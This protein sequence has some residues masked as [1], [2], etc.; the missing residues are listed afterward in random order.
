MNKDYAEPVT[1]SICEEP[2]SLGNAAVSLSIILIVNTL[3]ALAII[4]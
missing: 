2:I 3:F 4:G 1:N